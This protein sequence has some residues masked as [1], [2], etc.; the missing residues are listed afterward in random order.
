MVKGLLDVQA[1][2]NCV[3]RGKKFPMRAFKGHMYHPYIY[4]S[5]VLEHKWL[6]SLPS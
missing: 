5:G 6:G 4:T 1:Q 3:F 2:V